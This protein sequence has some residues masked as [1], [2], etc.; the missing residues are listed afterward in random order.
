MLKERRVIR[1]YRLAYS[2]SG[3][4]DFS[5]IFTCVVQT[6]FRL[7]RQKVPSNHPRQ[8]DRY[9]CPEIPTSDHFFRYLSKTTI[10]RD[11]NDFLEETHK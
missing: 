6:S 8:F 11:L 2:L 4:K 1:G 3:T 9:F 10:R 5:H 7:N